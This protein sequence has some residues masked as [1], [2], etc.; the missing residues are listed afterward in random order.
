MTLLRTLQVAVLKNKA[1]N[2]KVL[3]SGTSCLG[4]CFKGPNVV[5]Y[6][7]GIW[8]QDMSVDDVD[9][10]VESHLLKGVPLQRLLASV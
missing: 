8:Y 10:F 2:G 3:V 1:I 5:V 7:D 4:F 9:E 6:P